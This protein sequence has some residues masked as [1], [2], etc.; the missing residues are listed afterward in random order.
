M[1]ADMT[2]I[3]E[4][5]WLYGLFHNHTPIRFVGEVHVPFDQSGHGEPWTCKLQAV[6]GGKL[7]TGEGMTANLAIR[8]AIHEI[9]IGTAKG[10]W[11]K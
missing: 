6:T 4:G 8:A 2:N 11:G 5:W 3:P 7:V 9:E 10:R 1:I